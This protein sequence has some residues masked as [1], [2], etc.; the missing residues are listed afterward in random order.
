MAGIEGKVIAITG[1]SS[2]IGRAAALLLASRGAKLVL[3]ARRPDEL[4]AAAR[5]VE[6]MGGEAAHLRTDV[7]PPEAIARAMAFAIEQPD[8]VD[9]NDIVVRPTAQ[10]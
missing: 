3:G 8:D 6:A 4:D 5:E 2:G 1:A 10:A 9:V 7:T